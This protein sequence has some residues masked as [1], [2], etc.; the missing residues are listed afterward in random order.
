MSGDLLS[1]GAAARKLGVSPDT[2]RKWVRNDVVP[3]WIDP[4]SGRRRF[5]VLEL[6]AWLLTCS[7][8][9]KVPRAVPPPSGGAARPPTPATLPVR[10]GD[11]SNNVDGAS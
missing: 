7:K 5:S 9:S 4:L 8:D 1:S 3:V 2:L 11:D 10:S 6:D